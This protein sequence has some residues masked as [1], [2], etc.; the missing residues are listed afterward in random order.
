[1][2]GNLVGRFE[3]GSGAMVETLVRM[4]TALESVG[5]VFIPQHR[6][7]WVRLREAP[8]AKAKR[9]RS[10][11]QKKTSFLYRGFEASHVTS[12][13]ELSEQISCFSK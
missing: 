12:L 4:Q 2:S 1:V 9:S 5:V 8:A 13:P 7:S 11:A 3:N 10:G 6:R